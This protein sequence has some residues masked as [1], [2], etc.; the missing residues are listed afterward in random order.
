MQT[1]KMLSK[2]IGDVTIPENEK[3]HISLYEA[4]S[5]EYRWYKM[6]RGQLNNFIETHE[7]VQVMTDIDTYFERRKHSG[8]TEEI[9]FCHLYFFDYAQEKYI[10]LILVDV[11][12]FIM[13]SAGQTIDR[14]YS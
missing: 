14:I 5:I 8:M 10:Q 2:I 12:V 9:T 3:F 1:I 13:N 7:G 6:D 4:N 11:T